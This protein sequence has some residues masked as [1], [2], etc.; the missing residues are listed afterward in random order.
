MFARANILIEKNTD[1]LMIPATALTRR[2]E[3]LFVFVLNGDRTEKRAVV[4]GMTQGDQVE[5]LEG[6]QAD[7]V[8]VISGN[9]SLQEGD[10]VS[11]TNREEME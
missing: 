11:V 5:V 8:I 1:A 4:T 9:I 2:T 3:G 6:L 7:E 10:R